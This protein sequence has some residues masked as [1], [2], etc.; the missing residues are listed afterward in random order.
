MALGLM[1]G[2]AFSIAANAEEIA[3]RPLQTGKEP[4]VDNWV[5]AWLLAQQG[6]AGKPVEGKYA[7]RH[8]ILDTTDAKQGLFSVRFTVGEGA[9]VRALPDEVGAD[10]GVHTVRLAQGCCRDESAGMADR[11]L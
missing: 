8:D 2:L 5:D 11:A 7:V 3:G 9:G 10:P 4:R 6:P 1:A